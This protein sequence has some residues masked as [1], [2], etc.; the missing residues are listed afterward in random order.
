M[1]TRRQ[2]LASAA[3]PLAARAAE[4]RPNVIFLLTDDQRWDTLGAM[5]NR[6]IRTP[7]LDRMA[8]QGVVFENNFVTTAIC[9]TSRASIFTGLYAASHQINDFARPFTEAQFARTYPERMRQAGYYTGFIGKYGV[10]NKMPEKRF[11]YWAGFPGQGKYFPHGEEPGKKHLTEIMGG[12]ALEFLGGAPAGRP[13][14]LSVSFKAPH[15]Q[16]EDSRQFLPSPATG[17]LYRNVAFP[18][19]ETADPRYIS[20]LP[21]EVHRSEGRRRWG[22]RF[23]TPALYQESVRNY[24]RLISEVDTVVGRIRAQLEKAGQDRNTVIAFT[25]DNGFYLAEHGLAGKWLMHE[26]SIRT[27]MVLYDPRLG[28]A[29]RGRRVREMTLNIDVAPTLLHAAGL[30]PHASVQGRNLYEL[31]GGR[32]PD[33]RRDWFYEHHFTANGWIPMTEGVRTERWKYTR[34]L[35]TRPEFEELFDLG[36]DP[37]EKVN[38]ARAGDQRARLDAMRKRYQEW[39]AAL[40]AWKPDAAWREPASSAG[41]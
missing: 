11:D 6:I 34:Y 17:D 15:V 41:A 13:F 12:Q 39:K 20:M 38:L 25:G 27:P 22:V 40:A 21:Q 36:A 35:D 23:S 29:A 3:A 19:P 10:G 18:E 5:G 32:A 28:A 30:Q 9:M 2:F 4:G 33:W 8:E 37:K 14:C 7:H 31:A 1:T 24:Y 26:E 16:D